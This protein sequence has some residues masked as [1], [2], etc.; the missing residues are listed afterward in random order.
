M[1]LALPLLGALLFLAGCGT[2]G[3]APAHADQANGKKLFTSSCGGSWA[4]IRPKRVT[5]LSVPCAP[6]VSRPPFVT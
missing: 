4:Q 3:K 2:G 1:R 5:G 6:W